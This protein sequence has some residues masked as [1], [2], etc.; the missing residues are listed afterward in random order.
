MPPNKMHKFVKLRTQKNINCPDRVYFHVRVSSIVRNR[1]I[2]SQK[3]I[4]VSDTLS[5]GQA[6]VIANQK[7]NNLERRHNQLRAAN[8]ASKSLVDYF[9]KNGVPIG[10]SVNGRTK[11]GRYSVL[12]RARNN[13]GVKQ[14][15]KEFTIEKD[16]PELLVF[17]AAFS[18]AF[19]FTLAG[20]SV[21][22]P[23]RVLLA[24]KTLVRRCLIQQ[25]KALKPNSL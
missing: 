2:V 9:I 16:D 23:P 22:F 24:M 7:A 19:A 18:R 8:S 1:K 17:D 15:G 11:N 10:V 4:T 21:A 6:L 25:F 20:Q 3:Y 5:F 12:I 14:L 13:K